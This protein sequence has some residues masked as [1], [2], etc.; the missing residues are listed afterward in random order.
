MAS[1][2]GWRGGTEGPLRGIKVLDFTR[3]QNGPSATR[4]LADYGAIVV[5]VEAPKGG[6]EGRGLSQYADGWNHSVQ[7]LNRGKHSVTLD[8]RQPEARPVMEKLIKWCDVLTENFKPGTLNRY[9]YSYEVCAK[10]NPGIVY[11][12]NSGFG[13][14]GPMGHL[15]SFDGVAQAFTGVMHSQGGGPSKS[16]QPVEWAFSDEVGAMNFVQGILMALL[17]KSRTGEGQKMETSQV[18]ATIQFQGP[19]LSG[20]LHMKGRQP[21]NPYPGHQSAKIIANYYIC[22]DGKYFQLISKNII[23]LMQAIG[24]EDLAKDER[25]RTPMTRVQHSDWI[26]AELSKTFLTRPRDEWLELFDKTNTGPAGPVHNYAELMEH[27]QVWANGY[28]EKLQDKA[29]VPGAAED[30]VVI[31]KALK[32]SKTPAAPV[33]P[34]PQLGEHNDFVFKEVLGMSQ[35]EIDSLVKSKITT[36]GPQPIP[37]Q[38][39]LS[40]DGKVLSTE[41]ANLSKL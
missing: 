13:A 28:M 38:G 33:A 19:Q 27:P 16:P 7:Y 12:T 9:G 18:G 29:L 17:H 20:V 10:L 8:I 37:P 22:A 1:S 23:K 24:R 31:G 36:S 26:V 25:C 30:E 5:K 11:C 41:T 21:E 4:Q 39:P 15:G 40:V 3:F 34:G 35:G 32:F 2:A 14:K 6:D